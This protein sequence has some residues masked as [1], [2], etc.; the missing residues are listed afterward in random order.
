MIDAVHLI[1]ADPFVPIRGVDVLCDVAAEIHI[2]ELKALADA[3]HGL[4]F[5]RKKGEGLKL[6]NVQLGVDVSGLLTVQWLLNSK[7]KLLFLKY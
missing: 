5:R 4:F 7:Y 6:Q 2:D 3:E 1:L